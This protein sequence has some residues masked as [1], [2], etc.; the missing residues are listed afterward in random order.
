M[1]KKYK[2]LIISTLTILFIFLL[3]YFILFYRRLYF[4]QQNNIVK[5]ETDNIDLG[6]KTRNEEEIFVNRKEEDIPGFIQVCE[7]KKCLLEKFENCKSGQYVIDPKVQ[8]KAYFLVSGIIDDKCV[9]L[10]EEN[11]KNG[12][13]CKFPKEIIRDENMLNNLLSYDFDSVKNYCNNINSK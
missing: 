5:Q 1:K 11:M 4:V 6:L 12:T 2:V 13:L 7:D 9:V 10:I 3:I 8:F